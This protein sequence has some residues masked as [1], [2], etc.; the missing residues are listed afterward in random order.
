MTFILTFFQWISP[1]S[2][3]CNTFA[4]DKVN[5]LYQNCKE[6]SEQDDLIWW[7]YFFLN[8]RAGN[9]YPKMMRNPMKINDK[10]TKYWVC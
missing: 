1:F 5:Y 7:I 10:G 8:Q 3:L 9:V 4:T 2:I 6:K